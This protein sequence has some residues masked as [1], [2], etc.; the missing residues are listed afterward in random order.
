MSPTHPKPWL[1]VVL[2]LFLGPLGFLYIGRPGLAVL[3][4]VLT[5]GCRIV[6][7]F[8][9]GAVTMVAGIA[10]LV[11]WLIGTVLAWRLAKSGAPHAP[12]W[13]SRWYG[14]VGA[15]LA[16]AAC[17]YASRLFF[18]EPFLVPSSAM[19]PTASRGDRLLVQK[20]G[21]GHLS[22]NGAAVGHLGTSR[23]LARGELVVFD[24]PLKRN[25]FYFK[26][27]AGLPGDEVVLRGGRLW[28]NG[29]DTRVAELGDYRGADAQGQYLLVRERLDDIAFHTLVQKHGLAQPPAPLRFPQRERCAFSP[30]EVRCTVPPAHYFMLGDHRDFS[31]DSRYFGFVRA[32]HVIGKVVGIYPLDQQSAQE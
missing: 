16:V 29:R 8:S 22:L 32:D 13:Y 9:S 11:F 19:L 25:P 24:D 15:A 3:F 21:Y 30:Q 18:F 6:A 31:Q 7:F 12:R 4:F 27:V 5:L 28:V 17:V 10:E 14:L 23:P 1:A 2:S 26:R 20:L